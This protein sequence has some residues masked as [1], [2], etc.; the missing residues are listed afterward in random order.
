MLEATQEYI[1][2]A[3]GY[4]PTSLRGEAVA[5]LL[6]VIERVWVLLGEEVNKEFSR[7]T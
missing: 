6:C 1:T 4:K 5:P 7:E 2:R 3:Q